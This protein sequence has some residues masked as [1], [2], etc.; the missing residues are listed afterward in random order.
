MNVMDGF[1]LFQLSPSSTHTSG[2]TECEALRGLE[3][4]GLSDQL[5]KLVA[6]TL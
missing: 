3:M 2:A 4:R 6:D 1:C 5:F